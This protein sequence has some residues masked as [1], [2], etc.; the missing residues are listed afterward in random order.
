MRGTQM[1]NEK[2]YYWLKLK[3]DFFNQKYIKASEKMDEWKE[4]LK[5]RINEFDHDR[6]VLVM[7]F[8]HMFLELCKFSN[9]QIRDYNQIKTLL[10]TMS[11]VNFERSLKIKKDDKIFIIPCLDDV[12]DFIKIAYDSVGL[13]VFERNLLLKL[14]DEFQIRFDDLENNA[15]L[16]YKRDENPDC[17]IED[18]YENII[19]EA[20]YSAEKTVMAYSDDEYDDAKGRNNNE[21]LFRN[22]EILDMALQK[23]GLNSQHRKKNRMY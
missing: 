10:Q 12:N 9:V 22:Y 5:K 16:E 17:S 14:K 20:M 6:F 11:Y 7:P 13:K 8:R 19:K 21:Y 3:E 1:P 23:F 2:R 18:H 15:Y 4:Y